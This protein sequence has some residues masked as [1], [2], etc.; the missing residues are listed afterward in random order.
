MFVLYLIHLVHLNDQ[1]A[2]NFHTGL[3]HKKESNTL[4]CVCLHRLK[5]ALNAAEK[6]SRI[7]AL[8]SARSSKRPKVVDTQNL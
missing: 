3:R 2:N 8:S 4:E 5:G 1:I 6:Y 7:E